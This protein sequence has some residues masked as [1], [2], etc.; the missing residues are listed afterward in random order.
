MS[1]PA[2]VPAPRPRR[3]Y[4][5]SAKVLAANRANLVKA[6]E[7]PKA[8]R[9][10]DTPRRRASCF[11]NLSKAREAACAPGRPSSRG[12]FCH[13]LYN[14]SLR[15]SLIHAGES[16]AAFDAHLQ[17]FVEAFG[18]NN[19][20]EVKLARGLGE[21]VW[22]RWRAMRCLSEWEARSLYGLLGMPGSP[23]ATPQAAAALTV[24]LH[25]VFYK[26]VGVQQRLLKLNRR[27]E[28]VGRV[29]LVQRDGQ[30]SDLWFNAPRR[31]RECEML[32][33]PES[34]LSNPFLSSRMIR[35]SLEARPG[36][37]AAEQWKW[38]SGVATVNSSCELT[39]GFFPTAKPTVNQNAIDRGYHGPLPEDFAGHVAC[40]AAAFG[41][42]PPEPPKLDGGGAELEQVAELAWKRLPLLAARAA[43]EERFLRQFLEANRGAP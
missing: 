18:A 36:L 4:T 42:T 21:I 35:Q 16:E 1:V 6:R 13:G 26:A 41:L 29:F 33:H 11:A 40:F 28:R 19:P 8:I 39:V 30:A 15:R 20:D 34:A 2:P 23:Q 9:Y 22:R 10:R 14:K 43:E 24:S 25:S 5:V 38:K 37:A 3:P 12:R 27:L 31:P 32:L 7:V 17:L